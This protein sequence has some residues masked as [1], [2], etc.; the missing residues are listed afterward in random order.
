MHDFGLN[1]DAVLYPLKN[2]CFSVY[3]SLASVVLVNL[4][5]VRIP[6]MFNR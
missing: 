5:T 3:K 2:D 1:R 4:F 6:A